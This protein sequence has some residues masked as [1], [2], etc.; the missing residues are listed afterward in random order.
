MIT[1]RALTMLTPERAQARAWLSNWWPR[2]TR[3]ESMLADYS[4]IRE[5]HPQFL[6]DLARFCNAGDTSLSGDAERTIANEG[7]REVWLHIRA[8]L[9]LTE[10]DTD[11]L[12]ERTEE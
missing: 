9:K 8:M 11:N 1:P 5:A 12:L 6:A 4:A 2:R 10:D 7:R 3:A